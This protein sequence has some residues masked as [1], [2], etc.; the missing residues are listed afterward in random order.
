MPSTLGQ[1]IRQLRTEQRKSQGYVGGG[2]VSAS[3]V[4]LIEAGKRIPGRDVLEGIASRLGTTVHYLETGVESDEVHGERLRLKAAAIAASSGDTGRARDEYRALTTSL[5][6]EIA[7]Q[8]LWGLA[9]L[10]EECLE[11]DTALS[12]LDAL[13]RPCR[14]HEPGAPSR[15]SLLLMHCRIYQLVGDYTRSAETGETGLREFAELGLTG[16]AEE[17]RLAATLVATYEA[18]GDLASA[19]RLAARVIADAETL[20]SPEAL[21]TAYRAACQ[22]SVDR[23]DLPLALECAERALAVLSAAW[24]RAELAEFRITSA[25]LLLRL[26]PPNVSDADAH[27]EWAHAVL[28]QAG[29]RSSLARCETEMARSALVRGDVTRAMDLAGTAIR[30][31]NAA[32]DTLEEQRAKVVLGLSLI[33]ASL[34]EEGVAAVEAA[35]AALQE[36]LPMDAARA[37]RDLGELLL[38]LGEVRPA[39]TA[40]QKAADIAGVRAAATAL[41]ASQ[42]RRP[43]PV[44]AMAV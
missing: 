25:W 6:P 5:R 11:F 28:Q 41:P 14:Q 4:S 22:V 29:A 9:G 18:R 26:S 42:T 33:A 43:E 40:L 32:A 7:N 17:L 3:Y 30:R 36:R 8:A 1:R 15:L 16:T 13:D 44:P 24:D 39:V 12:C 21:S 10:E 23:G 35:A 37:W 34:P 19:H 2:S 20:G 27:L 38:A 31:C